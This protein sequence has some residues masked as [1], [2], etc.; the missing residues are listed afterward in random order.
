MLCSE[1]SFGALKLRSGLLVAYLSVFWF[2]G[3]LGFV[4]LG[5]KNSGLGTSLTVEL[6]KKPKAV[7]V[8]FVSWDLEL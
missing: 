4:S 7:F 5:L 6:Q 8:F 2:L 3:F 1:A